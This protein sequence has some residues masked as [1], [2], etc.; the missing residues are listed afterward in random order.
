MSMI[1]EKMVIFAAMKKILFKSASN[2]LADR[3]VL[4]SLMPPV[5]DRLRP[6]SHSI[7]WADR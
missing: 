3:S 4:K 7:G 1:I 5:I 6:V 2:A